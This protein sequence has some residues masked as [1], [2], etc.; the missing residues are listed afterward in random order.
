MLWTINDYPA[1]GTLSGCP[2]IGF[3]GCVVCGEETHC[4]RLPE[5][6][7]QSYAGHRRFLPYDHPFRRQNKA[8]N[9]QQ[10]FSPSPEPMNGEEIY[11]RVKF[12]INK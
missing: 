9:G 8:F 12:I 2:Y 3:Q 10:E 1:L 11:N 5:S 4:I 6:Y 7:K